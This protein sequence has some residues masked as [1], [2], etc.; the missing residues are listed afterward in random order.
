MDNIFVVLPPDYKE[1]QKSFF[2]KT[3]LS[4]DKD[5]DFNIIL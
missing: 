4:L 1:L 3:H 5:L 2:F